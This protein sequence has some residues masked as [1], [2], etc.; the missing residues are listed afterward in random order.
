MLSYYNTVNEVEASGIDT[1]LIPVGS[2]EQ[3]GSHLPIGMD[4]FAADALCKGIAEKL[5]C[6]LYPTIP[7]S[8]CYEHKG[9]RGSLCMRPTTFYSLVQDLVLNL[10]EQGFK[11][12]IFFIWHGGVFIAGPAIRELNALYDDI[13][14]IQVTGLQS[15]KI[16]ALLDSH[17][18]IHAGERETSL[19]LHIDPSTVNKEEMAKNDTEPNYPR[20]FLNYAS[21]LKL[22][23]NGVWG[24]PS[25]ASEEK[26]KKLFD[27]YVDVAIEYINRAFEVATVEKWQK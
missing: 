11:R 23:P 14:V 24:K 19:M 6:L 18:E 20:D 9:S 2:V 10:R 13:Q 17:G 27:V 3:H 8:T 4:Y 22:S 1:A 12:V 16:E 25:L 26:G 21:I 5:N 15:P 7:F